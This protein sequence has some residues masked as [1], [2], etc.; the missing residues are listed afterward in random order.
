MKKQS[1]WLLLTSGVMLAM[2][3]VPYSVRALEH[4]FTSPIKATTFSGLLT[5]II[6]WLLGLVAFLALLALIVGGI[7]LIIG[8]GNEEQVK[9]AKKIIMWAVIGL[10]VV[11]ISYVVIEIVVGLLGGEVI[12][13]G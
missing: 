13:R 6:Q 8:L 11:V 12:D 9:S 2:S 4:K 7:H 10:V 1:L 5:L 3:S